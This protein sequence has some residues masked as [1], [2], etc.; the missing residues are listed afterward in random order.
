MTQKAVTKKIETW[1]FAN[2][3]FIDLL[4]YYYH[5]LTFIDLLSSCSNF[6]EKNFSKSKNTY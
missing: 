5:L 6:T 4:I 2:T 1:L 3:M